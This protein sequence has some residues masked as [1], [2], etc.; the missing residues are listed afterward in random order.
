MC[1]EIIVKKVIPARDGN[2]RMNRE[3]EKQ[4]K[5]DNWLRFGW[6]EQ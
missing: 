2:A 1:G 6:E 3:G 4:E 5:E